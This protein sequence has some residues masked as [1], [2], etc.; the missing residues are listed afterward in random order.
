ML[1]RAKNV[2]NVYLNESVYLI[3][4]I[5][6]IESLLV[7]SNSRYCHRVAQRIAICAVIKPLPKKEVMFSGMSVCLSVCLM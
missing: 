6:L 7:G 5:V 2:R 3:T 4:Y 1:S